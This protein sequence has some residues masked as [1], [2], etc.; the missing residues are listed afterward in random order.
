MS[1]RKITGAIGGMFAHRTGSHQ[2]TVHRGAGKRGARAER[3]ES[4]IDRLAEALADPEIDGNVRA[5]AERLGIKLQRAN[6]LFQRIRSRINQAQ[7]AAGFG[8]WAV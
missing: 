5:A 1:A 6:M 8:D 2:G 3:P 7:R 4:T